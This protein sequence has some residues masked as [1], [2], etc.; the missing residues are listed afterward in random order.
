MLGLGLRSGLGLEL[1]AN[2]CPSPKA[3]IKSVLSPVTPG[4]SH[5]DSP[6]S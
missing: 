1:V 5:A 2:P 6:V 4:I 3:S